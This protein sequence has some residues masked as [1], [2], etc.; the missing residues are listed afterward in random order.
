MVIALLPRLQLSPRLRWVRWAER[1]R[2]QRGTAVFVVLLVIALLSALGLFAIRSASLVN[3]ATG[4]NRQM[5]Q[6]HYVT[7]YAVAMMVTDLTVRPGDIVRNIT[8][9]SQTDCAVHALVPNATC[10]RFA[11]PEM[12]S[13]VASFNNG[14]Q[15]VEPAAPPAAGSLGVTPLEADMVT[16]VTDLRPA[17]PPVAGTALA[18]NVGSKLAYYSVTLSSVGQVRPQAMNANQ[19]DVVS[20]SAAGVEAS[21]ARMTVGPLDL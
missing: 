12:Q 3:Q 21:R 14:F 7:D 13:L 5:T 17:W 19:C 15:V 1:R 2:S 8:S 16:E 10:G 11:M 18:G 4:Y 6:V 20:A 9:G